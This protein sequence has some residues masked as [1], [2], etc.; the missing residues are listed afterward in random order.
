MFNKLYN[1]SKFYYL[2]AWKNYK[3]KTWK[4]VLIIKHLRNIFR[5]FYKTNSNKFDVINVKKR[6]IVVKIE[7][8]TMN[9]LTKK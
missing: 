9:K 8:I 4:L 5:T 1:E 3:K 2:V 6:F 7:I